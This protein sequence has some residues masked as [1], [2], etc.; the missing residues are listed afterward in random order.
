L[1]DDPRLAG[2]HKESVSTIQKAGFRARD[3]VRQL[4]AFS[5]KQTLSV[6]PVDLNRAVKH[7]EPLLKRTIRENIRITRALSADPGVVVADI[8]QIE[9]V[10]MNLGV[11][12]ADAMPDGG[13]LTIET[14]LHQLDET[15]AQ[16]RQGVTPGQY[17]VLA[18]SDT[19]TGMD[20]ET[21]DKI[22]EP[23][24]STKG[25]LGTGLGL[26]TVYGIVKQH[27]GNIWVYSEPGKGTTFKIYL[28]AAPDHA[29]EEPPQGAN[30]DERPRGT[31]TILVVEDDEQVRQLVC[32]ILEKGGYQV[33]VADGGRKA[34]QI[35][36]TH[37]GP[38]QLMLTDVVMPDLNG[39]DLFFK[40]HQTHPDIKVLYMT[41]YTAD[42]IA[43]HGI[44]EQGIQ[45]IQKPFSVKELTARI[46]QVLDTA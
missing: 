41:G 12:A 4:L 3:L 25:D 21:C 2:P 18:V 37:E 32:T 31:E 6:K 15:D 19:G 5:R 24:F 46:R 28:P 10:I 1:L 26:A 36:D 34:L 38:I 33:L 20:R 17:V 42:V 11:N 23:F 9:Q 27:G 29:N 13:C 7:F 30:R 8:G 39:K 44:L 45:F 40:I 43:H 14:A 22:F 16:L 35:T